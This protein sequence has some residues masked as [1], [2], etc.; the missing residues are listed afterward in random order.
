MKKFIC[1]L[2]ISFLISC[3]STK[4]GLA[5]HPLAAG[6][7]AWLISDALH[8]KL[9]DRLHECGLFKRCRTP[10]YIYTDTAQYNYLVDKYGKAN[11]DTEEVRYRHADQ[12]TYAKLWGLT[13]KATK[14]RGYKTPIFKITANTGTG[15]SFK[16]DNSSKTNIGIR[17][18]FKIDN[19]KKT[20]ATIIY[21][22][23]AK[24]CPPP[25][26]CR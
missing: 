6:D 9:L 18:F 16:S 10:K 5:V 20:N 11:I 19:S 23:F 26:S 13:G 4:N 21:S 1:F 22:Y 8:A 2:S 25:Y 15:Y 14:V 17:Y 24:I 3:S 7:D 12:K